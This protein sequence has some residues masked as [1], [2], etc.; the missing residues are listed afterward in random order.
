MVKCRGCGGEMQPIRS[1]HEGG[2]DQGE[3]F[4]PYRCV[5]RPRM[6]GIIDQINATPTWRKWERSRCRGV[7]WVHV[8]N[9]P[10]I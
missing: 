2:S 7:E 5:N 10:S 4:W 8:E 9:V 6:P 1:M 3:H